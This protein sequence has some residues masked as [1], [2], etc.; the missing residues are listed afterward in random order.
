MG[1]LVSVLSQYEQH[2]R[3]S[4]LKV[5]KR[6]ERHRQFELF[7]HRHALFAFLSRVAVLQSISVD[8]DRM[9][10]TDATFPHVS[11]S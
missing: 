9:E 10:V 4:E 8:T 6:D 5:P 3:A 7:R 11:D 1:R 2:T